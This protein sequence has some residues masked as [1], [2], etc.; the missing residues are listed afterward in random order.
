VRAFEFSGWV[1][2]KARDE[3]S[4][5]RKLDTMEN[6]LERSFPEGDVWVSIDDGEPIELEEDEQ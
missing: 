6:V 3:R 1:T 4:A 2:I 5:R